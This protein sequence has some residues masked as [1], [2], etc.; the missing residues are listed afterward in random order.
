MKEI[1]LDH[2]MENESITDT[3]AW[4]LYRCRRLSQYI[5]LLRKDGYP[6]ETEDVDFV[7]SVTGRKAQ[8]ARYHLKVSQ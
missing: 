2:L 4:E 3:E 6:I 7:H 5:H 8:Y 1:I